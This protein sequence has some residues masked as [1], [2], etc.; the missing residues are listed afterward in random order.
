MPAKILTSKSFKAERRPSG[1]EYRT[2]SLG[3]ALDEIYADVDAAFL[4]LETAV[5]AGWDACDAASDGNIADLAAAVVTQDGVVLT[6]GKRLLVWQQTN[7]EENGIYV[8]GTVVGTAPLTRS[9]DLNE[10]SE[11]QSGD[12]VWV[13]A[14]T[15]YGKSAFRVSVVPAVL[16]TNALE[17][18]QVGTIAQAASEGAFDALAAAGVIDGDRLK[19]GG[20][21]AANLKAALAA[22]AI[23]VADQIAKWVADSV[24]LAV[25]KKLLAADS[26]D[27]ADV[28]VLA[29]CKADSMDAT[30]VQ[31]VVAGGAIPKSALAVTSKAALADDAS[32]I[33]AADF[34]KGVLTAAV[35]DVGGRVKTTPTAAAI[36]AAL[37]GAGAGTGFQIVIINKGAGTITLEM[38]VSVTNLGHAGDLT[39]A[40]AA[41]GVYN[42][43]I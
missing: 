22:D 15:S 26:L 39:L 19:A 10:T 42:V 21:T 4:L 40:T 8:L 29:A 14:G 30:F 12:S 38:D 5:N 25:F 18:V 37:P 7:K 32:V 20:L 28:D 1:M 33:A 41:T 31:K 3:L 24:T 2:G 23:N 43:L 35:I 6:A 17:F 16:G 36:V 27:F 34:V 13:K 11:V 9:T